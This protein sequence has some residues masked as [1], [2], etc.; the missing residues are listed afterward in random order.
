MYR[1]N[2]KFL[3]SSHY[4]T[5]LKFGNSAYK[6]GFHGTNLWQMYHCS[7]FNETVYIDN[8]MLFLNVDIDLFW[9]QFKNKMILMTQND[10]YRL[11]F[12]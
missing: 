9:Q 8:D 11:C 4:I 1:I 12:L 5:E 3:K 7:P 2:K 6:D 10:S